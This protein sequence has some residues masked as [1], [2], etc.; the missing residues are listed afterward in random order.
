MRRTVPSTTKRTFNSRATRAVSTAGPRYLNEA[1]RDR[2]ASSR[3]RESSVMMSAV[4]P[5]LKYCCSGS[6]PRFASG[7]TQ[8]AM[9]GGPVELP[10][11][12][13]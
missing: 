2:T 6:P 12:C 7:S 11:P 10:A 1:E 3:Q 4:M 9:R 13:G 5:S 8:M